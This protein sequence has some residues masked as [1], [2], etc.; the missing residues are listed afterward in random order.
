IGAEEF[1]LAQN[2]GIKPLDPFARQCFVE[3]IQSIVF[4]S[5]VLV[6]HPTLAD[7]REVDFGERPR[8][9]RTLISAGLIEPLRLTPVEWAAAMAIEQ[10]ALT[11]LESG[12]GTRS[13]IAFVEQTLK[14]DD[15]LP[16]RSRNDMSH[17]IRGW[18]DFQARHVRIAG[19]HQDRITT[20]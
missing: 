4:M 20:S 8:L 17:R 5:K 16:S 12:T 7:P 19:H 18:T 10:S 2:R 15:R 13:V 6:P 9:L 14:V 3:L 1:I 11:R